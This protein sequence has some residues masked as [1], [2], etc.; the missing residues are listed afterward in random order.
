MQMNKEE[1]EWKTVAKES[2]ALLSA[3]DQEK[4]RKD[5]CDDG[6][7]FEV[8]SK[9]PKGEKILEIDSKNG[10]TP[11]VSPKVE[12]SNGVDRSHQK[13]MQRIEETSWS[14]L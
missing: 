6:P 3:G 10:G 9:K 2:C 12:T 4:S 11:C 5:D 13:Q 14:K 8:G 1:I 7:G